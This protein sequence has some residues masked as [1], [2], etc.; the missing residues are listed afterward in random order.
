[1]VFFASAFDAGPSDADYDSALVPAC[2]RVKKHLVLA[3]GTPAGRG[4]EHIWSRKQSHCDTKTRRYSSSL[5]SGRLSC[6]S[7]HF[8]LKSKF[9][10][11]RSVSG[12]PSPQSVP[13][14]RD[15]SWSPNVPLF[16][17]NTRSKTASRLG[18]NPPFR[19]DGTMARHRNHFWTDNTSILFPVV[20]T[21]VG[22]TDEILGET[23]NAGNEA[24]FV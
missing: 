22:P 5:R 8:L 20:I 10:Y 2:S 7:R 21:T 4:R 9:N 12:N 17:S 15:Y 23:A 24:P 16:P 3:K 19:L 18:I 6:C 13:C 1:M 14:H 11:G